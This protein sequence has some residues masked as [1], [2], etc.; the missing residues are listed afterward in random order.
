MVAV[1]PQYCH[2]CGAELVSQEVHDRDRKICPDCGYRHFHNAVPAV[3]VVVHKG[4]QVLLIEQAFGDR[5]ELPGGHPE[6]EEEPAAAAVRELEEETGLVAR[7]SDLE[8][9][10]VVHTTHDGLHYNMIT[11]GLAYTT[12][13]G[14]PVAGEEATDVAFWPLDRIFSATDRTRRV[15]RRVLDAE[16]DRLAGR[17]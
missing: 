14:E 2:Q 8:L 16:F 11:Y 4:D 3:D 9:L 1:E 15:D 17:E 7:A 6:A 13:G 10:S 5:W 12:A